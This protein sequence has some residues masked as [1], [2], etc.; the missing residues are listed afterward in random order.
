MQYQS[1]QI[2]TSEAVVAPNAVFKK[3][4]DGCRTDRIDLR[5]VRRR[6]VAGNGAERRQASLNISLNGLFGYRRQADWIKERAGGS[7]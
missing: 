2:R 3:L 7:D 1:I 5:E 4:I 6:S